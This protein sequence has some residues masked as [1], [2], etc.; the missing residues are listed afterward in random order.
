MIDEIVSDTNFIEIKE[1]AK[2]LGI[3]KKIIEG[4]FCWRKSSSY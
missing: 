4:S 2:F 3:N 1:A